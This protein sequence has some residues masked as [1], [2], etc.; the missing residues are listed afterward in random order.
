MYYLYILKSKTTDKNHIGI[1]ANPET[2]LDH[3][4]TLEKGFTIT[5][6][7]ADVPCS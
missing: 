1:F 2:R 4:N 7:V 3:H 5:A 6:W